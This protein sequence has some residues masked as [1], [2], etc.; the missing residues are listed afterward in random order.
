MIMTIITRSLDNL[1]SH[2]FCFKQFFKAKESFFHL[3]ELISIESRRNW[4]EN[5]D[6]RECKGGKIACRWKAMGR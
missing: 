5:I 6:T 2:L 3:R 4:S 1:Q